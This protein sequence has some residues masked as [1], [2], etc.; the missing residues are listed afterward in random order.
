MIGGGQGLVNGLQSAQNLPI[1]TSFRK[2]ILDFGGGYEFP[3]V[4]LQ[5]RR[6]D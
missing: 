1:L 2:V 6:A 3:L 4:A 5:E